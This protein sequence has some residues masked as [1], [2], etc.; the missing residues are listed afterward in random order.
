MFYVP[1]A[2]TQT[3]D[4]PGVGLEWELAV[5]RPVGTQAPRALSPAVTCLSEA[6]PVCH[7]SSGVAEEWPRWDMVPGECR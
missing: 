2:L 5:E 4:T 6:V 1:S 3:P 7:M